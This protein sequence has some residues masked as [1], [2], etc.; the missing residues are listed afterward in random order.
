MTSL[1]TLVQKIGKTNSKYQDYL[2]NPDKCSFYLNETNPGEVLNL[3]NNLA[4]NKS[5]D[6]FGISPKLIKIASSVLANPLSHYF[7]QIL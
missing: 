4:V 6:L 2:K 7:Y 3:I 1:L 5:S